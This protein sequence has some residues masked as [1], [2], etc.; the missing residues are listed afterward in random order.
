MCNVGQIII[1]WAFPVT[2]KQ[3][4]LYDPM[5]TKSR[6]YFGIA[7]GQWVNTFSSTRKNNSDIEVDLFLAFCRL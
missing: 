6:D 1:F 7:K 3:E 5:L 4:A 2:L